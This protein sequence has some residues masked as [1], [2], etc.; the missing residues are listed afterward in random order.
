MS[1]RPSIGVNMVEVVKVEDIGF[2]FSK[3]LKVLARKPLW[4]E[5]KRTL[6]H[7]LRT[8]VFS[9]SAKLGYAFIAQTLK[10]PQR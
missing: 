3:I 9:K 10:Q 2:K 4:P 7:K 5:N 8:P 1:V 6:Q